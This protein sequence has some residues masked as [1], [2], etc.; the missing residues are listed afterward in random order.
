MTAY[1]PI[2]NTEVDAESPIT[3]SLMERMRDNP[4]AVAEGDPSVPY[5]NLIKVPQALRT[6]EVSTLARLVPDGAGNVRWVGGGF[7]GN[8]SDG[9][10]TA[11][12][13][14]VYHATSVNITAAQVPTGPVTIYCQGTV[15]IANT[16]TSAYPLTI[17]AD[18][19]I[20]IT[21]AV[22]CD[23]LEIRCDGNLTVS[24]ALVGNNGLTV[25]EED[26]DLDV[27]GAVRVFCTGNLIA[28]STILASDI[29]AKV[30]GNATVSSTWTGRWTGS[31]STAVIAN[32]SAWPRQYGDS[33][34]SNGKTG[35]G[36][37]NWHGSGAGGGTGGGAG[38]NGNDG[39]AIAGGAA[40]PY[41]SGHR[42]YALPME[43]LRRG[44]GGGPGGATASP[45]SPVPGGD[46]G[47]RI[48]LYVGG[49]LDATGATLTV[50]G[51]NGTNSG[52]DGGGG[53]GGYV[54]VVCKGNIDDGT[55]NANGGNG[56]SGGA[57]GGGG[58]LM[59]ASGY[60]GTQTMTAAAGS[61]VGGQGG[62][63]GTDTL[64]TD[65]IQS[66]AD[67]GVFDV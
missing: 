65:E 6:D 62:T 5:A 13:A 61:G 37:T 58:A 52:L 33:S 25:A 47:G 55:L 50:T 16:I 53:A 64:T 30:L 34:T 45:G 2:L 56:N 22:T 66:L 60:S 12:A 8:G 28:S 40:D 4:I 9:A 17:L 49:N 21:S 3:Q 67:S 51:Y 31:G 59:A 44:S 41:R 23:G 48:S 63:T 39:G 19:S 26:Q 46:G 29:L 43:K 11:I 27:L 1:D 10:I 38:G 14:G 32:G 18:D 20:T 57:G 24:A 15:T 54:R 7:G 36:A 35:Y 42:L